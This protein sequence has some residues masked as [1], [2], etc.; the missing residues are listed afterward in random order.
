MD[1]PVVTRSDVR[2]GNR[3][4]GG[5]FA[6]VR[7]KKTGH[8]RF[9]YGAYGPVGQDEPPAA[10]AGRVVVDTHRAK[11]GTVTDVLSD[12]RGAQHW[13]VVKTGALSGEHFMPLEDAYVD[14]A[15]RLVVRLNKTAVRH[16]PRVGAHHVLTAQRQR[17]LRVYYGIA[18]YP[19]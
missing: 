14:T 9:H 18:A 11:V 7:P 13:A 10:C 15:G 2:S 1:T 17:E 6:P 8:H 5:P 4:R 3:G 19:R 16:A 12:D